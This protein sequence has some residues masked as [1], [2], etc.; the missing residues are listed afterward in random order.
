MG[1]RGPPP[2]R[3]I[4]YYTIYDNRTDEVLAFGTAREIA[5]KLGITRAAVYIRVHKAMTGK[6]R[7]WAAVKEPIGI[8]TP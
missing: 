4:E 3:E 1:K 6:T 5:D 2:G 8:Q 7:R